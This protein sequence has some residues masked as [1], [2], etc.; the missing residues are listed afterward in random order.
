[1]IRNSNEIRIWIDA[2]EIANT[3]SVNLDT[4]RET[5]RVTTKPTDGFI[6]RLPGM[7]EHTATAEMYLDTDELNRYAVGDLVRFRI[8]TLESSHTSEGIIRN[9][10][11]VGGANSAPIYSIEIESTADI[12]PFIP[13]FEEN[14]WCDSTNQPF[15][16]ANGDNFCFAQQTN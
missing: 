10:G 4:T 5:I 12:A 14:T 11:R 2:I 8:G 7:R 6:E 15:C 9:I 13:L 3:I 16:D 1:M